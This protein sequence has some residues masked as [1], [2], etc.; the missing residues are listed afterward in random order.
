MAHCNVLEQAEET[1]KDRQAGRSTSSI[2]VCMEGF[3]ENRF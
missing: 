2:G 1:Q 3:K